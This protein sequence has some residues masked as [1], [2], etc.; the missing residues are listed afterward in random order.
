[1]TKKC[2]RNNEDEDSNEDKDENE[3]EEEEDEEEQLS[4]SQWRMDY[5]TELYHI[6]KAVHQDMEKIKEKVKSIEEKL[7]SN[8]VEY[9][10][11]Q[12]GQGIS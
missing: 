8:V 3:E 12:F 9:E 10:G 11:F 6:A 5:K 4:L 2:I 7:Q 1:M